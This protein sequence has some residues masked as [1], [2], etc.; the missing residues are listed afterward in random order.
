M[1]FAADSSYN[2]AMRHLVFALLNSHDH[3]VND[4]SLQMW[5][6]DKY[7]DNWIIEE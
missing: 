4:L 2:H 7:Y 3:F 6:G 5:I 1:Q